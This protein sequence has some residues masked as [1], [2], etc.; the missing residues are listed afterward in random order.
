LWNKKESKVKKR[1]LKC[2]SCSYCSCSYSWSCSC[3]YWTKPRL[4]LCRKN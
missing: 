4:E 3:W 2:S 1:D